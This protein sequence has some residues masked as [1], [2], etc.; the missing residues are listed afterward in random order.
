[1]AG[2]P[3]EPVRNESCVIVVSRG[4]PRRVDG[5][6]RGALGPRGI[7]GG[8]RT[9]GEPQEPVILVASKIVSRDRPDRVDSEN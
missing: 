9:V 3:Q 4:R 7:E 8:E 6:R 5:E 1:V 2:A